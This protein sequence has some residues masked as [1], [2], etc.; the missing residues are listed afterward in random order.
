MLASGDGKLWSGGEVVMIEE[1]T[2][3]FSLQPPLDC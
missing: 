1:Q 3:D 2:P